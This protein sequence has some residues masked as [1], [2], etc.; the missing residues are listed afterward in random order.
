[1]T[2]GPFDDT[3]HCKHKKNARGPPTAL[4]RAGHKLDAT[5]LIWYLLKYLPS[6][7]PPYQLRSFLFWQIFGVRC[8]SHVHQKCCLFTRPP[9]SLWVIHQIN[10]MHQVQSAAAHRNNR[11]INKE[12]MEQ[13]IPPFIG[14]TINADNDPA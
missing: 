7:L 2:S 3:S 14:Q 13:I 11:P 6:A 4:Y 9:T 1:M 8:I 12:C 5:T 10:Y